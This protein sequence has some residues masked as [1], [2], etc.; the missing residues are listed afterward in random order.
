LIFLLVVSALTPLMVYGLLSFYNTQKALK[1]TIQQSYEEITRRTAGEIGLY[2]SQAQALLRTLVVD[3]ANT[4]LTS[5]QTRRI[6]ENYVIRFPE[7]EKILLFDKDG[8]VAFSTSLKTQDGDLPKAPLVGRALGGEEIF[9]AAYLSEDL[10]PVIWLLLPMKAEN[11][12]AGALAAQI[13]LMRMWEWVS[14]TKL[15]KSGFV[16]VVEQDGKVV[17]SGDPFYKR[18]ILSSEQPVAFESFSSGDVSGLPVVHETSR[19]QVLLSTRRVAESPPWYIILSQPVQEAFGPLRTITWEL[20]I[21][22][23]GSLILMLLA[24]LWISRRL[25]LRPV[26]HLVAATQALGKGDLSHRVPALGDDELGSLGNS[27]N[28]MSEALVDL[29]EQTRRQERFVMF[30]RIASSLAH[31]L[32][33][34][35]K[36]IENAAKLMETLYEDSKYRETFTRIVQREFGRINQFLDDLRNLT[37]EM[38]YAPIPFNLKELFR[39]IYES[40]SAEAEKKKA[41][42]ALSLQEGCEQVVGDPS[43]LRRVFENL[44]SNALQAMNRPSG[45]IHIQVQNHGE[46][47]HVEVQDTGPGIAPD[48][49][50]GL[51]E[52]FMTTKG[53]GL[54]LGLAISRKILQMH[55]GS[56][57]VAS[58][59]GKGTT[60]FLTWPR[61]VG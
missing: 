52:E 20:L 31:D 34:P 41:S 2:L 13:D 3:L 58:E 18:A 30:G 35:V 1:T 45:E 21:L 37:H 59:L 38:P 42:L 33:H 57:T 23:V 19:G 5:S 53:R 51:F 49:L 24:A 8:K 6:L 27:F 22:I 61:Q 48:K 44:I 15:G 9:S 16:T 50:P 46:N 10:T 43:L 60:F 17:A 36:N 12:V 7:F 29:Q 28:L 47:L 55:R 32:K 40:F 14:S 39:E 26:H 11:V 56:I 25:I 54:G 4:N